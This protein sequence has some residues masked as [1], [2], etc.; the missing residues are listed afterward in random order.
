MLRRSLHLAVLVCLLVLSNLQAWAQTEPSARKVGSKVVPTYPAAARTM[1]LSG[2]VRLE[3]LV[4]S[5]GSVKSVLVKGG[6]PL[7]AQAAQDAVRG[8]KWEKSDHDTTEL[9]EF[10]FAP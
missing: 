6:N 7:L 10:K 3:V 8:W 4:L 2:T 5:N 1:N 9:V